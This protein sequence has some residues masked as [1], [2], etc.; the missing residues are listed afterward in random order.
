MMKTEPAGKGKI[1]RVRFGLNPN[2]SSLSTDLSMLIKGTV[3]FTFLINLVD[4]SLRQWR[5]KKR[6]GPDEKD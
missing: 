4:L 6:S 1:L 3:A 2:S 5:E